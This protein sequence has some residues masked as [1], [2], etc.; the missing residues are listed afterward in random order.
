MSKFQDMLKDRMFVR[1]GAFILFTATLLYIIYL[2]LTNISSIASAAVAAL[3]SLSAALAPLIIGLIIAYIINP[4]VTLAENKVGRRLVRISEDPDKA[5]KTHKRVRVVSVLLTY[6]FIVV[7]IVLLLYGLAALLM[8][9]LM[10]D[11]NIPDL[12]DKVLASILA[13]QETINNWVAN[14][15]SGM[16]SAQLDGV[17]QNVIQWITDNVS[18][19]SA[20][21]I[22]SGIGVSIFNFI[23]GVMVSIYLS[24]DKDFFIRLWGR[25]MSLLLPEKGS[26]ALERTLI[27]INGV[28]SRFLR[29]VLLDAFI[30][31]ILSSIGLMV[32]GLEFAVFVGI[33]AGICNIIPYFGPIIGM[34]PAFIIG[35]LTDGLWQGLLAI[36]ILF[37]IQQIDG[38]LIYPRV[39]GS[40][41][42]LHPLFVL[43][44]VSVGGFYFG[45]VG[46]ILAVPIAG[47]L[48]IFIRRWAAAKETAKCRANPD[49]CPTPE[50]QAPPLEPPVR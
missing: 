19:Q 3:A 47:I 31:G 32:S 9:R 48:Q 27:E 43:L 11:L 44:A 22:I 26:L 49:S 21:N 36:L 16:F 37:I 8:G 4:L 6:L 46:M 42:G 17:V 34:I 20:M 1:Y 29:G 23:I 2:I 33:F 45:L 14:L 12:Y 15:P 40:S 28:T 7:V 50:E 10:F 30:V 38:S 35:F 18:A 39:V 41:T 13:Y 24:I 5:A 25:T